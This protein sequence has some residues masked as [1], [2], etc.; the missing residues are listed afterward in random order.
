MVAETGIP[1]R[2]DVSLSILIPMACSNTQL[3]A[4]LEALI[5]RNEAFLRRV[6]TEIILI[7]SVPNLGTPRLP[8]SGPAELRYLETKVMGV[9]AKVRVALP[10]TRGE[11][12]LILTDEVIATFDFLEDA[13]ETA[14]L[15]YVAAVPYLEAQAPA[16]GAYPLRYPWFAP[17]MP[18]TFVL[19]ERQRLIEWMDG[20]VPAHPPLTHHWCLQCWEKGEI[21]AYPARHVRYCPLVKMD[22]KRP[23][24]YKPITDDLI[25]EGRRW[26]A[27]TWPPE[28]VEQVHS[29]MTAICAELASKNQGP[30][31]VIRGPHAGIYV[32]HDSDS[33]GVGPPYQVLGSAQEVRLEAER[34]LSSWRE[35]AGRHRLLAAA[36][37][38]PERKRAW[39]RRAIRWVASVE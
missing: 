22:G 1:G 5:G 37:S 7:D 16:A 30:L 13:Y 28:R 27:H 18:L 36:R 2:R 12:L 14:R 4:V 15:G 29:R 24:I 6:P 25:N 3:T 9:T 20:G 21:P 11:Y 34:A 35:G 32:V 38:A 10:E 26:F 23:A 33:T 19:T 17:I 39:A 8:E 31:R